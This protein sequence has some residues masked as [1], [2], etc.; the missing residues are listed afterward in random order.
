MV[1]TPAMLRDS[2]G[3]IQAAASRLISKSRKPRVEPVSREEGDRDRQ[4]HEVVVEH[5]GRRQQ[6]ADRQCGG[7]EFERGIAAPQP[8]E[9]GGER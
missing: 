6:A 1:V 9:A 2:S 5:V 3:T 4:H 8:G 7:L